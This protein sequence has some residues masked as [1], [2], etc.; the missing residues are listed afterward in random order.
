M[1]VNGSNFELGTRQSGELVDAVILPPW[2]HG[3]PRSVVGNHIATVKCH[4][5]W[6]V[7]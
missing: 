2:A 4:C 7:F 3:D 1:F 6:V 5:C